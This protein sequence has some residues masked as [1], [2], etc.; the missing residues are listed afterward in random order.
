M[1]NQRDL[2]GSSWSDGR[3]LVVEAQGGDRVE[4]WTQ[5]G[6]GSYELFY[7]SP[8]AGERH[9]G[10]LAW[11]ER[12]ADL[13]YCMAHISPA[14]IRLARYT[15]GTAAPTFSWSFDPSS[16]VDERRLR[17]LEPVLPQAIIELVRAA[18]REAADESD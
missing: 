15:P 3:P 9:Y 12:D 5:L 7:R 13:T 8:K 17:T 14:K 1:A 16:D 4:I 18:L 6:N 2:W 11:Q 10:K